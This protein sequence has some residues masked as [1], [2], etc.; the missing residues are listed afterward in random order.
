MTTIT[1]ALM[2]AAIVG[3]VQG[4]FKT[5]DWFGKRYFDRHEK[6]HG[7][8]EDEMNSIGQSLLQI[9]NDNKRI[10]TK[11]DSLITK[12]NHIDGRV[13]KNETATRNVKECLRVIG[14]DHKDCHGRD[15]EID[16]LLNQ[17]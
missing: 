17:T 8:E 7:K 15:L 16:Q 1:E 13:E 6:K 14:R 5:V 3:T 11:V 12:V 4:I 2:I 9:R 10:E